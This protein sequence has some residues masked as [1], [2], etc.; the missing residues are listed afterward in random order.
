VKTP[1]SADFDTKAQRRKGAKF[2]LKTKML[3]NGKC[4]QPLEPFERIE[5]IEPFIRV[6]YFQPLQPQKPPKPL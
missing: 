2:F 3:M 1:T 6:E 4:F 5:L